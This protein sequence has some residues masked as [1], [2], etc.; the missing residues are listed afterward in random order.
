MFYGGAM[1]NHAAAMI[2]ID[3]TVDY[4]CKMLLGRA[5]HSR[6]TIHFLNAVLRLPQPI[7]DVEFLNPTIDVTHDPEKLSILD[8]LARDQSGRMINIEV[9]RGGTEHLAN[10]LVYY[11]AKLL[12]G[13]LRKGDGYGKLLPCIGIC[14]AKG[15]LFPH[16]SAYHQT[17]RLRDDRGTSLTDCL[18]F[19]LLELNKVRRRGDN[20]PVS[21]PLDQWMDFFRNARGSTRNQLLNRLGQTVF[22]EAIGVLEMISQTPEERMLYDAREKFERDQIWQHDQAVEKGQRLGFELGQR[23]GYAAGMEAGRQVGVQ[24]GIEEGR[25][26]GREQGLV[27]GRVEGVQEGHRLGHEQGHREALVQQLRTYASLLREPSIVPGDIQ[28]RST[29]SLESLIAAAIA[30]LQERLR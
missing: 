15:T 27:E 9:Q 16:V 26:A 23:E 17:F 19:H 28:E 7:V 24:E 5:S 3:P 11:S 22:S 6:L 1:G 8:I 4:A 10:R 21:D 2:E 12:T 14:I 18:E 13:Q 30:R 20:A 25:E 29:E